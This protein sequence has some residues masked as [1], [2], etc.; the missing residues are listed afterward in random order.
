MTEGRSFLNY[1]CYGA[2]AAM[3]AEE[4]GPGLRDEHGFGTAR[5]TSSDSVRRAGTGYASL[6]TQSRRIKGNSC[7]TSGR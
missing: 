6:G 5:L 2:T 7:L 4:I 3:R 1:N